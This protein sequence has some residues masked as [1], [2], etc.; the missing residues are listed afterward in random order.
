MPR[1]MATLKCSPV[2]RAVFGHA[3]TDGDTKACSPDPR[4]HHPRLKETESW[5]WDRSIT[6]TKGV[7]LQSIQA[8]MGTQ[9]RLE[10]RQGITAMCQV[11]PVCECE[12][13]ELA[14]KATTCLFKRSICAWGYM[15]VHLK[16]RAKNS[17]YSLWF[18]S[19]S[20]LSLFL[21]QIG[22]QPSPLI[23]LCLP[24]PLLKS[25]AG[26]GHWSL[27]SPSWLLSR[28]S[29]HLSHLSRT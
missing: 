18:S 9:E 11:G 8:M 17:A 1:L 2:S 14:K 23:L 16:I 28:G 15:W 4:S 21:H 3:E 24:T 10:L 7:R 25:R 19:Y 12:T 29:W 13:G 22:I 26:A 6:K 5:I 20:V 27:P